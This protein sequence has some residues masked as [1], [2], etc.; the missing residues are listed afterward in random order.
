MQPARC[1]IAV[2]L[3]AAFFTPAHA[4]PDA[5]TFDKTHTAIRAHWDHWGYS[6]QSIEFTRYDGALLLDFDAPKNSTIDVTFTLAPD[7]FFVGAPESDRF[8][9]HLASADLFDFARFTTARF[10]ATKFETSDGKTG[11]MTGDLTVKDATHPV[12][13]DVVL[14]KREPLRGV[15]RAGFSAKGKIDRSLWGM[16]FGAPGVPNEIDITIETELVGPAVAAP[17]N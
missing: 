14:N 8:E 3:A 9:Q 1:A 4:A 5:Y 11:R 17:K 10:K 2:A 16:G 7:G 12:T 15:M 6:R 13:L